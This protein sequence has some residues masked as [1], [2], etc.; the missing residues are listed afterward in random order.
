MCV[1]LTDA[2]GAILWSKAF[3][4]S[5]ESAD[6]VNRVVQTVFLEER[7]AASSTDIDGYTVRWRLLN[8]YD[9]VFLVRDMLI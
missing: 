2:A 7:T 4:S 1:C 9:L 6:V 3:V 5:V 8:T